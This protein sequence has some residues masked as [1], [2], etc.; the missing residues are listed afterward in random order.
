MFK[1]KI[2]QQPFSTR[3]LWNPWVSPEIFRGSLRWL[4]DLSFD[5]CLHIS[6]A[7]ATWQ[8]QQHATSHQWNFKWLQGWHSDIHYKRCI[9]PIDHENKGNFS[10]W[11]QW[12]GFS[13]GSLRPENYFRHSIKLTKVKKGCST[14]S[15]SK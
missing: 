4:I 2:P 15:K 9:L 14:E 1:V 6:R 7:I 11:P 10:Y 8:S 3:V 12:T 5:G 13:K